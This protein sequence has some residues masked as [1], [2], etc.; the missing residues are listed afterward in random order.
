MRTSPLARALLAIAA[1]PWCACARDSITIA[2][3]NYTDAPPRVVEFAVETAR[4]A[5]LSAGIDSHWV[6]CAPEDCRQATPAG[7]PHMELLLMPRLLRPI[8]D[9]VPGSIHPAGFALPGI[10]RP[11][12]WA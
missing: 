9:S 4:R 12:A 6:I 11:R 2:V 5:F 3:A 1:C 7:T 8:D 10:P